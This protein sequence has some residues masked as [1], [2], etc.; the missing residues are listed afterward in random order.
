VDVNT[1]EVSR[2]RSLELTAGDG[3][4]EGWILSTQYLALG[5]MDL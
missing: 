2:V 3:S 4:V 5:G 1:A